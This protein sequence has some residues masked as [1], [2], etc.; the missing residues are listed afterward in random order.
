[1]FKKGRRKLYFWINSTFHIIWCLNIISCQ[2]LTAI[3]PPMV[4]P[5]SPIL[6]YQHFGGYLT[7]IF[8]N[9]VFQCV[10]CSGLVYIDI[11]FNIVPQKI[12]K[13]YRRQIGRFRIWKKFRRA[14]QWYHETIDS[15]CSTYGWFSNQNWEFSL[16]T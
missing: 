14:V 1:M 4:H 15:F 13:I 8:F 6:A 3:A 5:L 2:T 16:F 7:N 9:V 12:V 10:S 11:K